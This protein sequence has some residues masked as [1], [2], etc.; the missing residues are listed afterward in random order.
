MLFGGAKDS[1]WGRFGLGYAA[2][3][4][5]DLKWVTL[6]ESPPPYPF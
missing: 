1:D 3:E 2:E 6:R 5:T 4:F